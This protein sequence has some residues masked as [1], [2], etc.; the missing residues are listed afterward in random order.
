MPELTMSGITSRTT[1]KS[2][3]QRLGV[4]SDSETILHLIGASPV[5]Q[6]SK[7]GVGWVALVIV[8]RIIRDR[9]GVWPGVV[10]RN[11]SPSLLPALLL[12]IPLAKGITFCTTHY[13]SIRHR[14]ASWTLF[15]QVLTGFR[16]ASRT[17]GNEGPGLRADH[18]HIPRSTH[19]VRG[20]LTSGCSEG[21]D[22]K[23]DSNK[24]T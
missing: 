13:I 11:R 22:S 23:T 14:A 12:A 19:A 1:I 21:T 9:C 7:L 16:M 15:S 5:P 4:R 8:R 2:I 24:R 10:V 18:S 6:P 20:R 17:P 3:A